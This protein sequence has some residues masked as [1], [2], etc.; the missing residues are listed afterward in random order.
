MKVNRFVLNENFRDTETLRRLVVSYV[1]DA[2]PNRHYGRELSYV[3]PRHQVSAFP[4]LFTHL[5]KLVNNGEANDMGFSSYGVSMTT[6][7]EVLSLDSL[8]SSF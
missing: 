8:L 7:E 5:E 2:K 4:H 6:L 1:A 3:L